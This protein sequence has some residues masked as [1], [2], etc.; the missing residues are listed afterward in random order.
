MG[1]KIK[2]L[3]YTAT[4]KYKISLFMKHFVNY[5]YK[6]ITLI[7]FWK[8]RILIKS[9]KQYFFMYT[10]IYVNIQP[11]IIKIICKKEVW[12]YIKFTLENLFYT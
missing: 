6:Q 8:L 12:F 4:C 9:S 1:I 11:L 10:S 2:N 7:M 5:V 3:I